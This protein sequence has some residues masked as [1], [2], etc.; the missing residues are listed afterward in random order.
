MG[1]HAL[2]KQAALAL[3]KAGAPKLWSKKHA[4]PGL[5][6]YK[7]VNAAR[8]KKI[9]RFTSFKPG[10]IL[11]SCDGM[12]HVFKHITWRRHWTGLAWYNYIEFE[13][14]RACDCMIPGPP[15]SREDINQFLL[16]DLYET[17]PM[18]ELNEFDE[19]DMKYKEDLLSGLGVLDSNGVLLKLYRKL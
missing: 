19:K 9:I 15:H 8:L 18:K 12:N 14:G 3:K 2:R 1:N 5:C 17:F 11:S 4:R 6:F 10:D 13:D 16:D 7:E